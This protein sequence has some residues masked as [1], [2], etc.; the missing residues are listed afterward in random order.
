ML[1]LIAGGKSRGERMNHISKE[2][3]SADNT[4]VNLI[5]WVRRSFYG[6]DTRHFYLNH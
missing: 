5:K 4:F 6:L 3:L 1:P 2:R